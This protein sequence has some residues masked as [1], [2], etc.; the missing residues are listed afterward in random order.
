M[1]ERPSA[2]VVS[3]DGCW[4]LISSYTY[5][6]SRTCDLEPLDISFSITELANQSTVD[7]LEHCRRLR[8]T[9]Y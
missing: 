1:R 7:C 9:R 8:Y 6:T 2:W 4:E 5:F 3:W